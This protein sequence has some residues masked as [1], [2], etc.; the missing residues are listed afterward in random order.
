MTM[1]VTT[2]QGNSLAQMS[3]LANDAFSRG[4]DMVEVRLDGPSSITID[5][6]NEA[7]QRLPAGQW[8]A[9]CR[10]VS[11]GGQSR[12]SVEHRTAML[13]KAVESGAAYID[14]EFSQWQQST[15][16]RHDLSHALTNTMNADHAPG[17]ILSHHDFEGR[18]NDLM[19]LAER[20]A[21]VEQAN[22][23]KIAWNAESELCNIDAFQIM[24]NW[25][26][27][28]IAICMGE[29]GTPSRILAPKFGAFAS[30]ACLDGQ[31]PSA[32]GQLS[33]SDMRQRFAWERISPSTDIFGVVGWPVEHSIGPEVFNPVFAQMGL[34]ATYT[35]FP[36]QPDADALTAFLTACR[37][38]D[39]L[40]ILGL[41]VTI[42]HKE[43]A[44]D[45]LGE[46]ADPPAD[47]IGAAN[48]VRFEDGEISG[49][50]TDCD[51]AIDSLLA[52]LEIDPEALFEM[53]VDVLGAG[54][55]SR[56]AVAGLVDCGCVVTV[57]NRDRSRAEQL[58]KSMECE[59]GDWENRSNATGHLL[60]NCTSLGMWPKDD[61]SP[62]E[63]HALQKY[64]AVFDAVY[65]P[66]ET[67][68][69][70]DAKQ[71]GCRIIH[72]LEMY[73]RQAAYQLE[74]WTQHPADVS[75]IAEA[76]AS[77]LESTTNA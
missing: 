10:P 40:N 22:V 52:G 66:H 68:L 24:K 73:V 63:Q 72:G 4:A 74:Y 55:A 53:K 35:L 44:L 39:W 13:I 67:K 21:S 65:R 48:T 32:P 3:E 16:A 38:H 51:A 61:E 2:V 36:V 20:M 57:F 18:P 46:W 64:H 28:A 17:L 19:E 33:I 1:L 30:Y 37:D 62:M 45:H 77:A 8:I 9:T 27:E 29:L 25:P 47:L 11:D 54:G 5:E 50:N 12:A 71:A 23:I 56:A 75:L 43:H 59:V 34:D 58:A 76:A 26:D 15:T 42:P 60:I 7:S 31:E 49:C 70:H 41:S 69:L 14:F 6:W